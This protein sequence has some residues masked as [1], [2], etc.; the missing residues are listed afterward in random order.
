MATTIINCI[1][2]YNISHMNNC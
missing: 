1:F 2:S